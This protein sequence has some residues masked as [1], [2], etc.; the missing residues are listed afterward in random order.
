MKQAR[1]NLSTATVL[2]LPMW[3]QYMIDA[4]MSAILN[5]KN[6]IDPMVTRGQ[7]WLAKWKVGTMTLCLLPKPKKR[8]G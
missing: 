7:S 3:I 8:V 1:V 6:L 5:Y 2:S 4:M